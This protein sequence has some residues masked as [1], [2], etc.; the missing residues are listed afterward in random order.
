ME[1]MNAKLEKHLR[2]SV[3][4]RVNCDSANLDKAV[5]AAIERYASVHGLDSLPD[6]LRETA[7][8]RMDHPELTLSQLA[9]LCDPP[10]TKSCLN[11][12][13]R[14]LMELAGR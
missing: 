5:D 7:A 12:R 3:N 6:K 4:R 10:V 8:L 1:L 11:H 14:K 13:L 2:G 9:A